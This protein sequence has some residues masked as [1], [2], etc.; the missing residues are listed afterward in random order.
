MPFDIGIDIGGT[1]IKVGLVDARGRVLGRRMLATRARRGPRQALERVAQAVAELRG[2]RR[3][4]SIGV[5]IAGLVDHVHGI[6]RVP[7]NLPGWNGTPVKATLERLTGTPVFCANDV[8][9]VTLGEWLYGAGQGCN[10]L[11]CVTLG[12]GV[13]GGIISGGRLLLGANQAA[14]RLSCVL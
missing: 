13:G 7:P 11:F 4:R 9:A 5:G 14:R 1:N 12:T 8:N 10:D 2:R 6:V 3:L